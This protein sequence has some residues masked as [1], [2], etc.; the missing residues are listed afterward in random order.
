MD[1]IIDMLPFLFAEVIRTLIRI[2][3]KD[4]GLPL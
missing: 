3:I 2:K 4:H 1:S